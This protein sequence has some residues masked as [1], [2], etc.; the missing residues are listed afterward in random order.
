M[1]RRQGAGVNE[2]LGQTSGPGTSLDRQVCSVCTG[3]MP[4]RF[5][6]HVCTEGKGPETS[7][8]GLFVGLLTWW[9]RCPEALGPVLLLCVCLKSV[10]K[11]RGDGGDRLPSN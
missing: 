5:R 3:Q 4:A 11:V 2:A 7:L 9:F 8:A 6:L 1:G 10:G